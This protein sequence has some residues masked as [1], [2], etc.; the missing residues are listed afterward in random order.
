MYISARLRPSLQSI[1]ER[2]MDIISTK[3]KAEATILFKI[4]VVSL[5]T[6][7]RAESTMYV[8]KIGGD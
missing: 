7:P 6:R 1:F 8:L 2:L 5:S 4:L 3:P